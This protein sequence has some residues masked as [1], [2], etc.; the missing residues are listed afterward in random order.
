MDPLTIAIIL[1]F[2]SIVFLGGAASYLVRALAFIAQKI[3]V[4][5]FVIGSVILA[6]STTLPELTST[7]I[8]NLKGVPNLGIGV[9]IG[10]FVTNICLIMGL[11]SIIKS[12]ELKEKTES[13]SFVFA[14]A[15]II[16]FALLAFNGIISRIEGL[17]LVM[18]FAI[19]IYYLFSQGVLISRKKPKFRT[20]KWHYV[21][22]PL[23][24]FII[25]IA[26]AILVD[27]TRF[28]SLS[29]GVPLAVFGLIFVS[30]G[31]TTPELASSLIA[32]FKGEE[33]LAVGD[34]IGACIANILFVVGIVAL[35]KPIH[36]TFSYFQVPLLIAFLSTFL[37][38]SYVKIHKRMDRVLGVTL[39]GIYL[40][41]LT[42][43]W[44]GM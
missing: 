41:Y 29:I 8:S 40:V 25:V 1:F 13:K 37:F 22:V 6:L 7:I 34:L 21:M 44:F 23:A 20:M 17:L 31:T 14:L 30:I 12:Q 36:L 2:L 16:L 35:I 38:L 27:T 4:S 28:I 15:P 11:I 42:L 10:A 3:G 19:Y 39:L 18:M 26:A 5:E 32:T 24:V 43:I 33:S 9:V